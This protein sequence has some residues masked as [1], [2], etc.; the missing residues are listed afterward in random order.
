MTYQSNEF[1]WNGTTGRALNPR[2]YRNFYNV[3]QVDET[4]YSYSHKEIDENFWITAIYY[5]AE[6][7]LTIVAYK[8]PEI[9]GD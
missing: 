6:N 7:G 5:K 9:F 3:I 2:V 4:I 8:E 1:E